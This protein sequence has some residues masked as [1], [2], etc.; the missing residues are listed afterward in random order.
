[1]VIKM[2]AADRQNNSLLDQPIF[3]WGVMTRQTHEEPSSGLPF[4]YIGAYRLIKKLGEGGMG[5]VYL[6]IEEPVGRKV[7]I[8]LMQAGLSAEYLQRFND[9]RKV[10]ASLNQRNIV[11]MFASGEAYNRPYFVMEFL[12]GESLG[13]RMRRGRI[14]HPEIVEITRQICDALNAAHNREIVH[15]DIKPE[16]IFLAR[17]DDGLL[18]KVL[19]FG[20]AT[21]KESETRTVTGVIVGTAAYLSP[22]QARGLNRKQIDGRSDIYSL[23]GVVYEMLTG[24][25]AFTASDTAGYRHLHLNVMPQRPS[26]RMSGAGITPTMDDVVMRALA[27]EPQ[28]RY[29]AAREFAQKLKEAV[30]QVSALS[31]EL[32]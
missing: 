12:E 29:G 1:E 25:R 8:K 3:H 5:E 28:N 2:I 26:E 16:N 7:A 17:D 23:G 11:T 31:T 19:D 32:D 9:E 30:E 6:A 10:L 27:K 15:R 24:S 4:N 13:A 14:P 21:L 20:I 22:E 18:V